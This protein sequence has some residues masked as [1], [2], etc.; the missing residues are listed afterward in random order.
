MRKHGFTLI[1][2]LVVIAIIGILAAILLPALAGRGRR[3]AARV[4]KTTSSSGAWCSKCIATSPKVMYFHP[5][6]NF[7]RRTTAATRCGCITELQG[8]AFIRNTL[9][10]KYS[11]VS[12]R[13]PHHVRKRNSGCLRHTTRR[14]GGGFWRADSENC[15]QYRSARQRLVASDDAV[16]QSVIL[17]CALGNRY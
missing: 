1:E 3:R 10:H 15:C 4:A 5:R 14:R 2:L 7:F 6:Q 8:I 16:Y 17:L 13:F 9:R 12:V 11:Q